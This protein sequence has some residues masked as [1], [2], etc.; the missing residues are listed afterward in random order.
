[1]N[2]FV[3]N[4]CF[5]HTDDSNSFASGLASF[6]REGYHHILCSPDGGLT[7]APPEEEGGIFPRKISFGSADIDGFS[8]SSTTPTKSSDKHL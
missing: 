3:P 5:D 1:M 8:H 6:S 2:M 7:F 4:A